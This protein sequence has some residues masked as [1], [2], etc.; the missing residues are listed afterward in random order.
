MCLWE[1]EDN[2]WELVPAFTR[3][4]LR[5]E[6]RLGCQHLAPR[7]RWGCPGY[8]FFNVKE[9]GGSEGLGR[10]LFLETRTSGAKVDRIKSVSLVSNLKK[11][12]KT[13]LA[14]GLRRPHV[15]VPVRRTIRKTLWR[16]RTHLSGTGTFVKDFPNCSLLC[17]SRGWLSGGR[18]MHVPDTLSSLMNWCQLPR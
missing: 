6:L 14:L 7:S 15:H 9:T 3:R 10:R 18:R 13:N 4:A 2:L 1:S 17:E 5:V 11:Q 8:F 16:S 12:K